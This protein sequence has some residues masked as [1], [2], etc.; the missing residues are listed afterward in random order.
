MPYVTR[1]RN[2]DFLRSLPLVVKLRNLLSGFPGYG[3]NAEAEKS[4]KGNI[5]F[6]LISWEKIEAREVQPPF[7]PKIV[8]QHYILLSYITCPVPIIL[9]RHH[10]C[11]IL[12]SH[13]NLAPLILYLR[14]GLAC[15]D[16]VLSLPVKISLPYS[17][18]NPILHQAEEM[19][20][21]IDVQI[22]CF[23]CILMMC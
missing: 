5:F 13:L 11:N 4:I 10:L 21:N 6:K 9:S 7:K 20:L 22:Y 2:I 16:L 19:N 3:K 18:G 23:Q 14:H 17:K 8:S 12:E 15:F 1:R